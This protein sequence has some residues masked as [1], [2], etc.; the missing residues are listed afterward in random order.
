[1]NVIRRSANGQ[2]F[3]SIFSRNST[4]IRPQAF[5]QMGIEDSRVIFCAPNTMNETTIE[6]MHRGESSFR[7][8]RDFDIILGFPSVKTLGYFHQSQ[9]MSWFVRPEIMRRS[10]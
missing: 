2:C 8:C 4:E 6:G 7:P 3:H 5:A 10:P 1:M 9:S